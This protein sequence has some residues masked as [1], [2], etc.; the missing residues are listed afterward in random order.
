MCVSLSLFIPL[1]PLGVFHL[2][3]SS[4][5]SLFICLICHSNSFSLL[6]CV[7]SQSSAQLESRHSAPAVLPCRES[8][9]P[10]S[11]KLPAST[12]SEPAVASG[13]GV[14]KSVSVLSDDVFT[15]MRVPEHDQ[16]APSLNLSSG[17][18]SCSERKVKLGE[19]AGCRYGGTQP[20]D[21]YEPSAVSSS[22]VEEKPEKVVR[23]V[24]PQCFRVLTCASQFYEHLLK[25]A[26]RQDGH[27]TYVI[28]VF[29]FVS[30]RMCLLYGP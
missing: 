19:V 14:C 29:V 13:T 8:H 18:G 2:L 27:E 12:G 15:D 25:S 5:S 11:A 24:C 17:T 21:H 1:S 9:R 6:L 10:S 16:S 30:S 23:L 7:F 20:R 3:S 26:K 4:T 28:G 22:E